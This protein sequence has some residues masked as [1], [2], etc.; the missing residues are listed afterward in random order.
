MADKIALAP[1][2]GMSPN[3]LVSRVAVG[4]CREEHDDV[5]SIC[6]G[7]TSADIDGKNN[8]MLKKYPIIAVNGCD[9]ACVNKILENKG[10]NVFKT[11]A[12][13]D[14]LKDFG[15]S[16]KDPFR[17]DSECEECVKII[18]NKLDEKINEIKDY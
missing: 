2:N 5:I 9:G 11:V 10:I 3:G 8:E 7:S 18:K 1:C 4:D 16:S 13:V 6:M 14:V 12:V 17:L 15:V